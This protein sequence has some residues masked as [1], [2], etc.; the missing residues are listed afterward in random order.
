[1]IQIPD[2]NPELYMLLGFYDRFFDGKVRECICDEVPHPDYILDNEGKAVYCTAHRWLAFRDRAAIYL[3]NANYTR[4]LPQAKMMETLNKSAE[5]S[6]AIFKKRITEMKDLI[7]PNPL[8]AEPTAYAYVVTQPI[9]LGLIMANEFH[10][11][12]EDDDNYHSGEHMPLFLTS[13]MIIDA[14]FSHKAELVK[15]IEQIIIYAPVL[16]LSDSQDKRI[17]FKNLLEP[18]YSR[19]YGHAV[20]LEMAS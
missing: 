19:P 13:K 18:I 11:N 14:E 17:A 8:L 5:K 12:F 9:K 3:T 16:I 10:S 7:K 1:M 6:I 15:A 2:V 20:V 4:P